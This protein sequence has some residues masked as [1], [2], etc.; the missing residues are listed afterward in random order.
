MASKKAALIR[1]GALGFLRWKSRISAGAK[2]SEW[3]T[4]VFWPVSYPLHFTRYSNPLYLI[5]LSNILS[6]SYSSCPSTRMGGGGASLRRPGIGSGG[7]R[8]SFVTGKTG[9]RR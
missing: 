6:T 7:A 2:T 9:Q 4:Q 8:V 1:R 3:G 5:L